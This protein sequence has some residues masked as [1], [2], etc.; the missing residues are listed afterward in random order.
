LNKAFHTSLYERCPN[1]YLVELLRITWERLEVRRHTDF[2]YILQRV[3][4]AIEEHSQFLDMIERHTAAN[5]IGQFVRE[6]KLLT[7][8][9]YRNSPR[10]RPM[11]VSQGQG[12]STTG[13]YEVHI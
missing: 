13:T 4:V 2:T 12:A 9:A 6:H 7:S 5:E 10:Y 8:Q 3:K 11:S 1:A